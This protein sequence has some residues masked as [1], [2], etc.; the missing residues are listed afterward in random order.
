MSECI[1]FDEGGDA[2]QCR[3]CQLVRW[4]AETRDRPPTGRPAR[5]GPTEGLLPPRRRRS[6]SRTPGPG[7]LDREAH[8]REREAI[9]EGSGE[10]EEALPAPPPGRPGAGAAPPPG[11]PHAVFRHQTPQWED[12]PCPPRATNFAEAVDALRLVQELMS[13]SEQGLRE[14]VRILSLLRPPHRDLY[15]D[16]LHGALNRHEQNP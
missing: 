2:C 1:A 3:S 5:G 13:I 15:L 7:P 10:P 6:R 8:D 11:R 14:A 16:V 12:Q 9:Y 4:M